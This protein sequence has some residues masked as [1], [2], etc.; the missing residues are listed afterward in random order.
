MR[1]VASVT[2]ASCPSEPQTSPR[3]SRPAVPSWG[4][5]LNDLSGGKHHADAEKVVRG[6]AVLQ[7]VAP[8]EFIPIFPAIVHASCDDGS[9]A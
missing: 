4:P 3:M 8:P 1:N 5:L 2:I 7:A 9:G 6:H